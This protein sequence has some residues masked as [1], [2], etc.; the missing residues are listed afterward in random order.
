METE[1][2]DIAK[3]LRDDAERMKTWYPSP[4]D[5]VLNILNAAKMMEKQQEEIKQLREAIERKCDSCSCNLLDERDRLKAELEEERELSAY[6]AAERDRE[7]DLRL[8]SCD[9]LLEQKAKDRDHCNDKFEV[10][11][12][13]YYR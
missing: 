6:I 7:C 11:G 1:A 4:V 9:L 3:K 2:D 10:D 8:R 13:V 5:V 12:S